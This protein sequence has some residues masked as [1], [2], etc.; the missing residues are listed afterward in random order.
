MKIEEALG[1]TITKHD[2]QSYEADAAVL[3]GTPPVGRGK[4]EIEAKY[5]LVLN[6]L[7]IATSGSDTYKGYAETIKERISEV[8]E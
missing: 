1:I 4:T 8:D 5:N 6:L 2:D 7:W 3:C